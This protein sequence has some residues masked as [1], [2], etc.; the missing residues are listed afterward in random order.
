MN[1]EQ[2]RNKIIDLLKSSRQPI[3]GSQL[4]KELNVSRQVIVQD[5]ALI[6]AKGYEIIATPQGYILYSKSN[7]VEYIECKNHINDEEIYKEFK[8]IVDRGAIIKNVIV[9]HPAYGQIKADLNISNQRDIIAFMEKI[10]NN[11]FRQLSLLSDQ[12]HIHTIEATNKEIIDDIIEEL[13]INN[14]ISN[15]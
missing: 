12:V 11:E 8:I 5:V 10:K 3:K 6:R 13:K 2:R 4:S 15:N 7:I 1:A 14:F 9:E